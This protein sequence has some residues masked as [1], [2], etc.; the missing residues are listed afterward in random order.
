MGKPVGE[1]ENGLE[2]QLAQQKEI[3]VKIPMELYLKLHQNKII[4]G[5]QI[6]EVVQEALDG[7]LAEVGSS[8]EE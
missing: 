5:A 7:Y 1:S 8:S 4:N 2:D 3:K 6:K